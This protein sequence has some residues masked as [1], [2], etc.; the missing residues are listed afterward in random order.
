M[1]LRHS[2]TQ[3]TSLQQNT[4]AVGS[5]DPP[6]HHPG[7]DTQNY[8][9]TTFNSALAKVDCPLTLTGDTDTD[10]ARFF[11]QALLLPQA[12]GQAL[13]SRTQASP[14]GLRAMK[15]LNHH[16]TRCFSNT[17][18][19]QSHSGQGWPVRTTRPGTSSPTM[20]SRSCS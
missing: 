5:W 9:P 19:G 17:F 1:C 18:R 10:H 13:C 20:C 6:E 8:R 12:S 3:S 16:V 7:P 11:Y 4:E 15:E 2:C 14:Q